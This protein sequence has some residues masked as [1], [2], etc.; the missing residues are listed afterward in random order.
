[1]KTAHA[2]EGR[3]D[4]WQYET[5]R[6]QRDELAKELAE[7]YPKMAAQLADIVGRIAAND[8]VLERINRK[9][10]PQGAASLASA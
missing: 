7:V 5:A 4:S 10:L 9:S 1:M 3:R 2:R 8:L 6:T